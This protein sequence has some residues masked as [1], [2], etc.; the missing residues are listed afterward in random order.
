MTYR[1]QPDAAKAF[2]ALSAG[3]SLNYKISRSLSKIFQNRRQ[4]LYQRE[5]L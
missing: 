4:K 2:G 1:H 5:S 3:F